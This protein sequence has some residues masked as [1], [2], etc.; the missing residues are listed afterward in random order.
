MNSLFQVRFDHLQYLLKEYQDEIQGLNSEQLNQK[1][2]GGNW[3]IAEIIYH[4]SHAEKAIVQYIQK[5]LNNPSETKKAGFK[6]WYKA[7][8]PRLALKSSRKFKAPKQLDEPKGPYHV[9]QLM[10]EWKTI[11]FALEE[12]YHQVPEELIRH[13]LFKHPVV[14]KINLQ[15]TLGFMADHMQRH[16][17]QIRG[18][19]K[20]IN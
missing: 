17:L 11:R 19:K 13:Q 10:E 15:Q 3:S 12:T 1:S 9:D 8:L 5:K 4:I 7:S 18:I 6:S 2:E 14:G 20:G 16:L